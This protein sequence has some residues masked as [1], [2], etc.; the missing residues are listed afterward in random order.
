MSDLINDIYILVL[1]P[2][3][4][5]GVKSGRKIRG[6]TN[7]KCSLSWKNQVSSQDVS[8]RRESGKSC[9]WGVQGAGADGALLKL[10]VFLWSFPVMI[11][12]FKYPVSFC[13]MCMY[14]LHPNVSNPG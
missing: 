14:T 6:F 12:V 10:T 13:F 3:A 2:L 4:M 7:R 11:M 5:S 1:A 9:G 8:A